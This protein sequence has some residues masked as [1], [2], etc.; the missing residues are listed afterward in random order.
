[1]ANIFMINADG[2]LHTLGEMQSKTGKNLVKNAEHAANAFYQ[3]G[4]YGKRQ[5]FQNLIDGKTPRNIKSTKKV[6]IEE[7]I[8][9]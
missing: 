7:E 8:D 9:R 4:I 3:D 6:D 5:E 2:K 1:M